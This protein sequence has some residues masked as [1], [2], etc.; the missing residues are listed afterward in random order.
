MGLLLLAPH[1]AVVCY[2]KKKNCDNVLSSAAT[3]KSDIRFGQYFFFGGVLARLR[4]EFTKSAHYADAVNKQNLGSLE[5]K[6]HHNPLL[7]S[8]QAGTFSLELIGPGA[9]VKRPLIPC[10][11]GEP[12]L[13][14]K[15]ELI[16][17]LVQ[18]RVNLFSRDSPAAASYQSNC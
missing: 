17:M 7:L 4:V 14:E 3:Q 16:R 13:Q 6:S 8:V 5:G 9:G 12:P 10:F 18:R 15:G 2:K 1:K 11:S